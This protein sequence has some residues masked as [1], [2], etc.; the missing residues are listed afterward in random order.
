MVRASLTK[1]LRSSK[2]QHHREAPP[3][4]MARLRSRSHRLLPGDVS[5]CL[6]RARGGGWVS[7]SLCLLPSLWEP[8]APG[9][10]GLHF[11]GGTDVICLL[12]IKCEDFDPPNR[13]NKRALLFN[14][15]QYPSPSLC[16]APL[17]PHLE[18]DRMCFQLG[19]F[20]S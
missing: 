7:G 8:G 19:P 14:T 20:S 9:R 10:R 3:S 17:S 5:F 12:F 13:E 4:R 6:C 15:F 1:Q 16:L 11:L 18:G 2:P